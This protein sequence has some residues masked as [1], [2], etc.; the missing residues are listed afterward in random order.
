MDTTK[1]IARLGQAAA[2]AEV[3]DLVNQYV[4]TRDPQLL[5]ALPAECRIGTLRTADE[6]IGCAY[7]LSAYHGHDEA[8]RVVQRLSSFF[9]QASLRLAEL[10]REP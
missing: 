7:R 2:P 1:W 10:A 8:S 9:A 5:A 6:I 4:A 3:I